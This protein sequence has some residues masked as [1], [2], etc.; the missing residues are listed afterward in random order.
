MRHKTSRE[1]MAVP[2]SAV[3]AAA[4]LLA[5]PPGADHTGRAARWLPGTHWA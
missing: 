4:G 2:A 1:V 3:R 5:H